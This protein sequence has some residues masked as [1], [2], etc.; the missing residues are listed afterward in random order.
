MKT[1]H[2]LFVIDGE[3][4]DYAFADMAEAESCAIECVKAALRSEQPEAYSIE[5]TVSDV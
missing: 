1:Y 5:F 4:A 3:P 2:V